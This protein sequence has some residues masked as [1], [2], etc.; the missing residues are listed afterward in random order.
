[1]CLSAATVPAKAWGCSECVGQEDYDRVLCT[2]IEPSR[3]RVETGTA[4]AQ[5][6]DGFSQLVFDLLCSCHWDE[7]ER[8]MP[9][10]VRHARKQLGEG[11][12]PA[13]M[14]FHSLHYAAADTGVDQEMVRDIAKAYAT[15]AKK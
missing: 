15:H 3:T 11:K 9:T 10:L 8:N 7:W 4:T 13:V 6:C 12:V 1:M 2:L 14:P 5:E